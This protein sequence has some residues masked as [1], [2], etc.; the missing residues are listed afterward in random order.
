MNKPIIGMAYSDCATRDHEMRVRTYCT[1]KYYWA[2]QKAGAQVVLLPPVSEDTDFERALSL[3]DGLLLPGGED[4][5]PVWQAEDPIPGLGLMNPWRDEYE[6]RLAKTCYERKIPVL[7]ICRG[8]QIMAVALGGTLHQDIKGLP[9]VVKHEQQAPRWYPSHEVKL[10]AASVLYQ[11]LANVTSPESSCSRVNVKKSA[12]HRSSRTIRVNSFH[13]Q[14]VKQVPKGC[15]A[16]A[17]SGDR[18]IEALEATA[19]DRV[20]VGVQWHPEELF[21]SDPCSRALFEGFVK[22]VQAAR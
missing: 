18:L 12:P 4:I 21:D 5:D 14:M 8:I 13:H 19:R 3:V 9:G 17:H 10:D 11:W 2:L 22:A 16:V 1:H 6:L 7:G 20:F 15:R